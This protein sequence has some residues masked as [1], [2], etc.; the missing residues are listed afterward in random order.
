[1]GGQNAFIW[2]L[3]RGTRFRMRG[4]SE[5][6][7]VVKGEAKAKLLSEFASFLEIKINV[8]HLRYKVVN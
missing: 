2:R 4:T 7:L 3:P 5:V 6:Q 1:M 8:A